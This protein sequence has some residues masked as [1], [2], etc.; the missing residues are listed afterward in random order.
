[1]LGANVTTILIMS[2]RRLTF[3]CIVSAATVIL[4]WPV[5]TGWI[6]LWASATGRSDAVSVALKLGADIN[7]RNFRGITPLMDAATNGHKETLR[8]LVSNGAHLDTRMSDGRTALSKT[9]QAGQ[10]ECLKEL[11]LS[12][13]DVNAG[14]RD[15]GSTPL[16]EAAMVGKTESVKVLLQ[17][18][19]RINAADI[20]GNN[21]LIWACKS[22]HLGASV[23]EQAGTV[24]LLLRYGGDYLHKNQKGES[25]IFLIRESR[26]KLLQDIFTK[27]TSAKAIQ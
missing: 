21:A 4:S 14:G 8:L 17:H 27:V 12:G 2:N 26:S 19:A 3:A 23:G 9:A 5:L 15:E 25:A 6:L 1:M 16:M 20:D 10:T 22:I 11:L 7:Y 13:A 24:D 18:G